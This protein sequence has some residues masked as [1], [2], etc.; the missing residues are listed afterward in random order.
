MS[1]DPEAV[2]FFLLSKHYRSPIDFTEQSIDEATGGLGRIYVLLERIEKEIGALP[3][4]APALQ[5]EIDRSEEAKTYWKLFCEAMDDDFNTAKGIGIL[6]DSVRSINRI[7]D[8]NKDNP[9]FD[10]AAVIK[11]FA[12]VVLRMGDVLGILAKTPQEF[13]DS[14]KAA[15]VE[16][17]A[18]DT[19]MIEKLIK[20]REAARKSKDFAENPLI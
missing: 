3:A 4:G 5:A 8:E 10:A 12:A 9:V 15:A 14:R 18:I 11:P 16:S 20:E 19:E 17:R 13:F 6:F 2:R 7:L 1:Y